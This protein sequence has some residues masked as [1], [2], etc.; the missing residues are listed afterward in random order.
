VPVQLLYDISTIDKDAVYASA[1]EIGRLNPQCGPMRQLDHVI[2]FSEDRMTV[3]GVKFV[4]HD[5]FWV[6]G[7]IPGRPL[8][9]GVLMIEAAAQLSSVLQRVKYPGLGFLGFTRCDETSFRG[10]VVPGDTLYLLAHEVLSGRRR[11]ACKVQGIVADR[12]V[13]ESL[14][15]G[16]TM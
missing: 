13:F 15:T 12:I 7:H 16:M 9:P 1:E 6:A 11:F 4:R 14:I 2:W 8:Y 3:L 5:E 10:Q